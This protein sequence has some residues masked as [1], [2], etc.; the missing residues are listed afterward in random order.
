MTLHNDAR[1]EG[2]EDG[3][4]RLDAFLEGTS[5]GCGQ[6]SREEE[7]VSPKQGNR[8]GSRE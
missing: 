2:H 8:T 7:G 1:P 3:R 4:A 5:A 6:R